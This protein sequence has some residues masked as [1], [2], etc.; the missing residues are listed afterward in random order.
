MSAQHPLQFLLESYDSERL[1]TLSVWSEFADAELSFRPAGYARTPLEHMV[2]QC[3]SEDTWLRS[4]LGIEIAEPALP[5]EETRLGFLAHY[6]QASAARLEQLAKRPAD[7]WSGVTKFFGVERSRA[8]VMLRRLTHSAHH[9]GQLTVYLRLL[10][11]PLYSTYGPTADTGGLLV[12]GASTIYRYGS[13]DEL[14]SAEQG[15][16]AWPAL[17]GPGEHSPTERP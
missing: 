9:R 11:K 7:W 12:R 8:W 14:L 3:V 13:V 1:K 15:R 2:H 10:G 5:P 4:M 17:P 6:A 16:G